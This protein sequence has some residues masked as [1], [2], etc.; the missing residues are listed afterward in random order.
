VICLCDWHAQE[1]GTPSQQFV[2]NVHALSLFL[3]I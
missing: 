3:R 2:G 1:R